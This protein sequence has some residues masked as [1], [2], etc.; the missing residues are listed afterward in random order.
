MLI[1]IKK[2]AVFNR[3]LTLPQLR[4]TFGGMSVKFFRTLDDRRMTIGVL[5]FGELN[6]VRVD[7]VS[8][9]E[10]HKVP[11]YKQDMDLRMGKIPTRVTYT[12]RVTRVRELTVSEVENERSIVVFEWN[13]GFG[14]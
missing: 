12:Q 5:N 3:G 10:E 13:G 2:S 6:N 11:L 1:R 8:I 9:I 4:S 14:R 7:G